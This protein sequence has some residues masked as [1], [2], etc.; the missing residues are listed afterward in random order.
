M[1]F[2]ICLLVLVLAVDAKA[3][4]V[5]SIIT[6]SNKI[7]VLPDY[8]QRV[9]DGK[10]SSLEVTKHGKNERVTNVRE[11]NNHEFPKTGDKIKIYRHQVTSEGTSKIGNTKIEKIFVGTATVV[12]A[13]LANEVKSVFLIQKDKNFTIMK[14]EEKISDKELKEI[15]GKA[16]VAIPDDGIQAQVNDSVEFN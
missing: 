7:V 12:T 5:V 15:K 11:V 14:K 8:G 2:L 13:D 3:H 16:I 1:K 4:H 9:Q 6:Q 10:V